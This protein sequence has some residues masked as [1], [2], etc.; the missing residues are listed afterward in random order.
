MRQAFLD[1]VHAGEFHRHAHEDELGRLVALIRD[2]V[3]D[4]ILAKVLLDLEMSHVEVTG[5]IDKALD[6]CVVAVRV[7]HDFHQA[8]ALQVAMVFQHCRDLVTVQF[9]LESGCPQA[10]GHHVVCPVAVAQAFIDQV[11]LQFGGGN[12]V[13]GLHEHV[14]ND[15]GPVNTA[16]EFA[17]CPFAPFDELHGV[18]GFALTVAFGNCLDGVFEISHYSK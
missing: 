2:H 4:S 17:C 12:T 5:V 13:V 15:G 8:L 18:C 7:R 11:V 10:T 16:V 9:F 1:G 6:H 3:P 14:A